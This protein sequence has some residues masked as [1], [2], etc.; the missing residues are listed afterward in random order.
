[1]KPFRVSSGYLNLSPYPNLQV[2]LQTVLERS[3]YHVVVI[4]YYMI[5]RA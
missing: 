2:I 5:H 3:D 4:K 1:M